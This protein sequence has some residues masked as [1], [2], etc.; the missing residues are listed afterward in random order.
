MFYPP[1]PLPTQKG[2]DAFP[3]VM[4]RPIN[5][6][7]NVETPPEWTGDAYA[8]GSAIVDNYSPQIARFVQNEQQQDGLSTTTYR[9]S[10]MNLPGLDVTYTNNLGIKSLD[11]TAYPTQMPSEKEVYAERLP[12]VEQEFPQWEEEFPQEKPIEEQPTPIDMF[13]GGYILMS[14]DVASPPPGSELETAGFIYLSGIVQNGVSTQDVYGH[15]TLGFGPY[16]GIPSNNYMNKRPFLPGDLPPPNQY[17]PVNNP[18]GNFYDG[19]WEM[20]YPGHFEQPPGFNYP[21]WVNDIPIGSHGYNVIVGYFG[22]YFKPVE[23]P[24]MKTTV[25]INGKV[26]YD[27]T[28]PLQEGTKVRV[29]WL[30]ITFGNPKGPCDFLRLHSF[31]DSVNPFFPKRMLAKFIPPNS[32]KAL[33]ALLP[34]F[35]L[36]S[37]SYDPYWKQAFWQALQWGVYSN[38]PS[39]PD[40]TNVP[41]VV[42][43]SVGSIPQSGIITINVINGVNTANWQFWAEFLDRNK[44]QPVV[45]GVH[46]FPDDEG[47]LTLMPQKPRWW[48]GQLGGITD[49]KGG[50]TTQTARPTSTVTTESTTINLTKQHSPSEIIYTGPFPPED[51]YGNPEKA[52]NTGYMKWGTR[53][54]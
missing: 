40:V 4:D 54:N 36:N 49:G 22:S 14:T 46:T 42:K 19:I 10:E 28:L 25:K 45:M 31:A 32:D 44:L 7:L 26:V 11:Y 35:I 17:D 15:F 12:V 41:I 30:L 2:T 16:P 3:N 13:S 29:V 43:L 51:R 27:V 48:T 24:P 33:P 21:I 52:P 39:N 8:A 53:L 5:T 38:I 6:R 34:F 47:S 23:E 9:Q 20:L 1:N 18:T 50:R 37:P